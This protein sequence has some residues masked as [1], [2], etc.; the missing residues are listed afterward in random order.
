MNLSEGE[1]IEQIEQFDDGW[2]SGVGAGGSKRGLFPGTITHSAQAFPPD[3][4]FSQSRRT[5]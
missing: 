2:W 1:I 4:P 3:T 5:H